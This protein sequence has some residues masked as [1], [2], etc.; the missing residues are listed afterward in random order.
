MIVDS[1]LTTEER[2]KIS[3]VTK[4]GQC[5][6]LLVKDSEGHQC[7]ETVAMKDENG[8]THVFCSSKC[9][10]S[11]CRD[12]GCNPVSITTWLGYA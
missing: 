6:A 9:F 10:Y 1:E 4:C 5:G 8:Q 11:Y 7:G 12:S 2:A 3:A